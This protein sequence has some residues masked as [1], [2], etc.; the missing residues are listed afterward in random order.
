MGVCSRREADRQIEAGNVTIC[1]KVAKLGDAVGEKDIVLYKGQKVAGEVTPVILAFNKP[2]GIV[3]TAEKREKDNIVDYINYP[4]RIYPIGIVSMPDCLM[5]SATL[6]CCPT[7]ISASF[8]VMTDK[9]NNASAAGE[10]CDISPGKS[11]TFA[12]VSFLR[13]MIKSSICCL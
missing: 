7:N 3:C 11:S 1:G 4:T 6:M 2:K 8:D 5:L 12:V 9:N 13:A 10:N